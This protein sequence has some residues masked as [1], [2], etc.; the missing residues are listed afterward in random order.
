MSLSLPPFFSTSAVLSCHSSSPR[1][2]GCPMALLPA[3]V[4][5]PPVTCSFACTVSIWEERATVARSGE[6]RFSSL[7]TIPPSTRNKPNLTRGSY[8]DQRNAATRERENVRRGISVPL[9][10][11]CSLS[12]IQALIYSNRR[13]L[14]IDLQHPT[15]LTAIERSNLQQRFPHLRSFFKREP[16]PIGR[17]H[18]EPISVESAA[19]SFSG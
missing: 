19:F 4:N 3:P 1:E 10:G 17:C 5:S 8:L 14:I 6:P 2:P 9:P 13:V 7:A 16:S 12:E 11:F 15:P 18:F